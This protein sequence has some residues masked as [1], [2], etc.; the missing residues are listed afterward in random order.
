MIPSEILNKVRLVEIK[1]RKL[2]NNLFGGEY[3]SAFKGSGMEFAEV[4]E[5]IPGDDIRSIDWNV[6]ARTGKPY[7]KKYDE[8][9]ELSVIIMV[10]VSASS[11][12]GTGNSL[13]TDVMIELSS[14]ISFSA[15][16]NNDK[17][18]L[19][20]F[21]DKIEKYIPPS[22][23]KKH[24]LR[25]IRELIYHKSSY[26]STN[27]NIPLEHIQKVIKRKSILFLLSDFWS[28]DFSKS[29][30]SI[31][32]KHDLINMQILDSTEEKIIDLGLIKF[33]DIETQKSIWLNT[34]NNK[35]RIQINKNI[36]KINK[37]IKKIFTK[38]KI[39]FISINSNKDYIKPLEIFFHKRSLFKK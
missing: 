34:G 26:N 33:H 19:L 2:V 12:F 4:R 32:K 17:V 9:R 28:P 27:I 8:E 21:S 22:K 18:G 11:F 10:D 3:H 29:I 6:T 7:I 36:I 24:V 31:N 15:I 37:N 39:D 14:I 13:K 25:V 5:Y 30:K 38:N 16:K 20:L 35:N 23:G 1:T